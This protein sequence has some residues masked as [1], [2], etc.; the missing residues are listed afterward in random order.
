MTGQK[1]KNNISGR[2]KQKRQSRVDPAFSLLKLNM[3]FL[4]KFPS[5]L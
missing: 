1:C 5:E 3:D 4:F 2:K